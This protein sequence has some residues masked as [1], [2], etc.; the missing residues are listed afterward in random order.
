MELTPQSIIRH[1]KWRV[2]VPI[3]S[4]GE[5]DANA[6]PV[7]PSPTSITGSASVNALYDTASR[8]KLHTLCENSRAAHSPPRSKDPQ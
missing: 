2:F 6:V 8:V 1:F 3:V 7:T 4:R 5:Y